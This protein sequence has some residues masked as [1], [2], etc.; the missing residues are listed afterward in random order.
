MESALLFFALIFAVM[1]GWG[2]FGGIAQLLLA[3]ILWMFIGNIAGHIIR[4]EDYG[5]AGNIALGLVGGIFGAFLLRLFGLG[6]VLNVWIFG[7]VISGVLG[8]VVLVYLTRWTID[9]RAGR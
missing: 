4:G 1:I 5:V 9:S 7:Q 8:A 3:I 2:L 6:F